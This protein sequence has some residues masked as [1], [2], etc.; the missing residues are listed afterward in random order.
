MELE[1][2]NICPI[3]RVSKTKWILKIKKFVLFVSHG[4]LLKSQGLVEIILLFCQLLMEVHGFESTRC[5]GVKVQ[6]ATGYMVSRV[7]GFKKVGHSFGV[8][9][10]SKIS[11]LLLKHA[12]KPVRDIRHSRS[13]AHPITHVDDSLT[14]TRL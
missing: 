6:P 13:L 3:H 9:R 12:G 11:H 5:M 8:Y 1:T 14:Q 10:V 7:H 2:N 4:V